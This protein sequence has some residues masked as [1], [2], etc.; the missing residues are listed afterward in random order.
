MAK[1]KMLSTSNKYKPLL[2]ILNVYNSKSAERAFE[3]SLKVRI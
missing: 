1:I 2:D 3:E